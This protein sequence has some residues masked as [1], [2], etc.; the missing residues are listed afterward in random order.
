MSGRFGP[1]RSI[2]VFAKVPEAGAVKTRLI[3]ALGARGA[4]ALHERLIAETLAKAAALGGADVCLWLA[5]D[6]SRYTAPRG[7]AVAKQEG[8][9][10]GAR[11]SRAFAA[12]LARSR[13]CALIGTDC[14]AL[15]SRHLRDAFDALEDHDVVINPAD[16]GGYVLIALK[17][18][19][20]RLFEGIAWGSPTVLDM[21]R[22][23]VEELGLRTAYLATL[24][25]LDTPEDLDR[26]R[27]A[28]WLDF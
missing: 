1:A 5:G 20:P 11:M 10:L 14:P 18:P 13:A 17:V 2:A 24:P 23:R 6:I 9:D 19:Q 8:T 22:A 4:A 16:D 7:V 12:T 26:A 27:S 3:P 21:T 15:Q 25:D 28:G